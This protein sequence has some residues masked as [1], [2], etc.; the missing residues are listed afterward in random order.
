MT[1]T[2]LFTFNVPKIIIFIGLLIG[3]LL[4][5]TLPSETVH[6]SNLSSKL[7]LSDGQKQSPKSIRVPQINFEVYGE[8]PT[9][10][11]FDLFDDESQSKYQ[12]KSRFRHLRER[13]DL[14]NLDGDFLNGK[15]SISIKSRIHSP[16][17]NWDDNLS[18]PES[19][20]YKL[21][22]N[23]YCEFLLQS[24]Q[25]ANTSRL[26]KPECTFL[27]FSKGSIVLNA[28]LTFNGADYSLLSPKDLSNLLIEGSKELINTIVNDKQ[29]HLGF[30][31]FGDFSL[32]L[33][34]IKEESTVTLP[35]PPSSLALSFPMITTMIYTNVMNPSMRSSMNEVQSSDMDATATDV[36]LPENSLDTKHIAVGFQLKKDG[37]LLEWNES[38]SDTNSEAYQLISKSICDL[39]LEALNVSHLDDQ[40]VE[41]VS[42]DFTSGSILVQVILRI[43]K[44]NISMNATESVVTL[45]EIITDLITS[46]ANSSK[47]LNGL[48]IDSQNITLE[49]ID[50]K[51]ETDVLPPLTDSSTELF[52]QYTSTTDF[53]DQQSEITTN[54]Y[55]NITVNLY[56]N[57]T[58]RSSN[59]SLLWNDD[60]LN[61]TSTIYQEISGIV[62]Q[63]LLSVMRSTLSSIWI[64]ECGTIKFEE[65]SIGVH[66]ELILMMNSSWT[67][68]TFESASTML[69][70]TYLL[71]E[72]YEHISAM[73]Q[74]NT[75]GIYI[76]SN[77]SISLALIARNDETT[78]ET[79]NSTDT[80]ISAFEQKQSTE[81]SYTP[82]I[83]E[84]DNLTTTMVSKISE[85]TSDTTLSTHTF[86][87]E[88]FFDFPFSIYSTS[89]GQS[90]LI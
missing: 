21:L 66:A 18:D 14:Q 55:D 28:I 81:I 34:D 56:L 7:I 33:T 1:R 70:D 80:S 90:F 77:S 57:F 38:L 83:E 22:S 54:Q 82:T 45:K 89:T 62:C 51:D 59:N 42:V 32:Q 50:Y 72:I 17:N 61:T 16:L 71:K 31:S 23:S 86:S 40:I 3:G 63:I 26:E 37:E 5:K 48:G 12:K 13:R 64:I 2:N 15:H 4:D 9:I 19:K 24:L 43:T 88:I 85:S 25:H 74:N 6:N 20:I 76:D 49:H 52:T 67:G 11:F 47:T 41:C 8:F 87:N 73:N 84:I 53:I 35:T 58:I 30:N 78:V 68:T 44:R 27:E 60:L 69:N 39:I 36:I 29:F 10:K 46:Y 79:N 65:G 75:Y